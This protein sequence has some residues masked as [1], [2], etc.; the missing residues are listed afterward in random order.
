ME[1]DDDPEKLPWTSTCS[2]A[3][4]FPSYKDKETLKK[5]LSMALTMAKGHY[6][7]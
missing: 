1:L 4:F 6:L 2:N 5:K 7:V 3:L